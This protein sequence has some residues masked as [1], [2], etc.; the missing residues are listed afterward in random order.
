M[1][2]SG[3]CHLKYREGGSTISVNTV[4]YYMRKRFESN[5]QR[6]FLVPCQE[7]LSQ[8]CIIKESAQVA[9]LLIYKGFQE[10]GASQK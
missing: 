5:Q 6:T 7:I 9:S 1:Q 3:P 4:G 10:L 8:Q 2:K